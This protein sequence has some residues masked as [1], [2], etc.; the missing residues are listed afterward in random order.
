MGN[1]I[2][3]RIQ[4]FDLNR[5]AVPF[6]FNGIS[7]FPVHR[8]HKGD[9]PDI[10]LRCG[11]QPYRPLDSCVIE[12]IECRPVDS[13]FLLK[14]LAR[15]H[16]RNAGI[17][18]TEERCFPFRPDGQCGVIDPVIRFDGQLRGFSRSEQSFKFH[19]KRQKTAPV[20]RNFL[21]VQKNPRVMC[22]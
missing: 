21:P 8:R 6:G 15:F 11:C 3:F 20:F 18:R 22:H 16:R 9:I 10:L 4:H 1:R 14:L 17:V 13:P 5:S 7:D 12:E 2:A 19:L